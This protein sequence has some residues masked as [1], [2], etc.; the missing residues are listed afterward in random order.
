MKIKLIPTK[1]E[2]ENCFE[3]GREFA[4]IVNGKMIEIDMN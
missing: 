2:L 1:E 4:E 3:F